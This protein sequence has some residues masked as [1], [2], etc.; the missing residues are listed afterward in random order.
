MPGLKLNL[1]KSKSSSNSASLDK[2]KMPNSPK[3]S[4]KEKSQRL[5]FSFK[6]LWKNLKAKTSKFSK[7][8]AFKISIFVSRLLLFILGLY[9][10]IMPLA[11]E[12]S[13]YFRQLT[14]N[15]QYERQKSHFG[16]GVGEDNQNKPS[17]KNIPKQNWLYIPAVDINVQVVEGKTED[18]LNHGAW[19][20]PKSS[21]PEKGGNTVITGHR[22]KYLPPSNLTFYHLDKIR[23]GD[24]IIVYW[25]GK[26]YDYV[27]TKIFEVKPTQIEVEKNTKNPQLTL[28]TCTPLWTAARRLV[29]VA[30]PAT[31]NQ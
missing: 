9:L 31:N 1:F 13:Y 26:E 6:D 23:K 18:A 10:I 27:V 16:M 20:R 3:S 30:T 19:R 15:V 25:K 8:K 29:I 5:K 4:P 11:P 12:L 2:K 17:E 28:Y 14:G 7:T 22:F 24:E 21:T